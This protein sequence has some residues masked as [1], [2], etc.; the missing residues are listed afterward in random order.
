[1]FTKQKKFRS[2]NRKQ[3]IFQWSWNIFS[4]VLSC[5]CKGCR[6]YFTLWR[7]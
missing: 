4:Y 2:R 3:N 7:V 5:R 6:N 1:M